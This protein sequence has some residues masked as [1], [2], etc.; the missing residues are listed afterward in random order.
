MLQVTSLHQCMLWFERDTA[1]AVASLF[2][3]Y[4]G[5]GGCFTFQ[6]GGLPQ[7]HVRIV[8]TSSTDAIAQLRQFLDP[9]FSSLPTQDIE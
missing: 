3:I 7:R 2:V 6:Q 4:Q 5:P 1:T 9:A 8:F